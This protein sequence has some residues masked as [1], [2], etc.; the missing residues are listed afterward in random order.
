MR[1][2]VRPRQADASAT[3]LD[4][5]GRLPRPETQSRRCP[6]PWRSRGRGPKATEAK[7]GLEPKRYTDAWREL[8]AT[9]EAHYKAAK[10][11]ER[12]SVSPAGERLNAPTA[13]SSFMIYTCPPRLGGRAGATACSGR[14]RKS[15]RSRP[16]GLRSDIRTSSP[17]ST[18]RNSA[19]AARWR[20]VYFTGDRDGFI[21]YDYDR[22]TDGWWRHIFDAPPHVLPLDE[23]RKLLPGLPENF[24][25]ADVISAFRRAAKRCHPDHGGTAEQ[26]RTLVEAWDR[27]LA[28]IGRSEPPPKPPTFHPAGG[29]I[30]YRRARRTGPG[31]I[32]STSAKRIAS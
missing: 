17:P 32:G 30:V 31:R 4:P 9:R 19:S 22:A 13:S 11:Q 6:A 26:F 25:A 3:G 16:S 14:R 23:A 18:D 1:G 28:S 24:T 2:G 21:V 7:H 29:R 12:N 10:V 8:E 27:L 20:G 5:P 15:S